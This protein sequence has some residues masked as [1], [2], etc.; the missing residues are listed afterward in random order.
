MFV[1][2]TITLSRG[3]ESWKNMVH[4]N[5]AKMKNIGMQMVFAGTAATDDSQLTV[6]MH[7]D[8]P[9][10]LEQFKGDAELTEERVKAGAVMDTAVM[11]PMTEL[12]FTN[13]P[14]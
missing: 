2:G 1:K 14:S 6:I 5:E 3:F 12:S 11:T 7:F 4:A 10:A 8:S 13:F 9:G